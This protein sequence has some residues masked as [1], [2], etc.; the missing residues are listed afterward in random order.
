MTDLRAKLREVV[1][2]SDASETG[3]GSVYGS[4]LTS[5]T[6]RKLCALEEAEDEVGG[7]G[8]NLDEPQSVLVFDFF[9][10]IGGL[11]RVLELAGQKVDHLVVIEK[12]P[13]CRRLNK[14]RWPGCDVVADI[15]RATKGNIE[16]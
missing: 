6:L 4:K 3:G 7:E 2:A 15:T 1:T 11:S 5:R 13:D 9:A 8:I 12:D 10:G 14:T 16:K